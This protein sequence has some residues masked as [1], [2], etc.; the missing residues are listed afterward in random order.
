MPDSQQNISQILTPDEG[1]A[2]DL[3]KISAADYD[4]W[5]P[6]WRENNHGRV[7][8]DVTANT[9][10]R[11]IDDAQDVHGLCLYVRDEAGVQTMA[12][13]LHYILH[14]VT[15][16]VEPVCYMQDVFIASNARRKGYAKLLIGALASLGAREKW[17]RIY[18]LA[19]GDNKAAQALYK[20]L[21]LKLD[22]TFLV[23]PL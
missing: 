7:S 8:D 6:L 12:G 14:P 16:H 22:F 15:G 5:L 4:L 20:T 1:A 2:L 23:L 3:R 10:A 19:E 18:W 13:Q 9:W 17:A 21:G 11:L